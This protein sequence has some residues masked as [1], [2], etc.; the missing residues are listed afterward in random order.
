MMTMKRPHLATRSTSRGASLVFAM[1]AVVALSLAAVAM[2]RSVDTGLNI[3]GNLGF[4]Q[5][6]LLAADQ[7][8]QTAIRWMQTQIKASTAALDATQTDAGYSAAMIADLDPAATRTDSARVLI[9]WK[10]DACKSQPGPTPKACVQPL[11]TEITDSS[12]GLSSRYLI[13]RMCS[14]AGSSTD[15]SVRC[16]RPPSGSSTVS[17]ERN[18]L[19]SSSSTRLGST[20]V[21]EYY[22]IIVRTEGVRDT[23]SLTETL[24]HF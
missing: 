18:Q 4:K 2:V 15:G 8:T 24:V 1:M 10:L 7:A 17:G 9:D 19:T 5:D 6:T 12:S 13:V 16:P 11:K 22:R 3:L 23:V 14:A 21:T 20:T